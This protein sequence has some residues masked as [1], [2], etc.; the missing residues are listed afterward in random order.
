MAEQIK[1][2][3][4]CFLIM[5]KTE[6]RT[7]YYSHVGTLEI[8]TCPECGLSLDMAACQEID[9]KAKAKAARQKRAHDAKARI[10]YK[11][12]IIRKCTNTIER[13]DSAQQ[14]ASLQRHI[15]KAKKYLAVQR[16]FECSQCGDEL[17]TSDTHVYNGSQYCIDCLPK[18]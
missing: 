13:V 1:C 15:D 10:R 4:G 7:Y 16:I 5:D 8:E 2:N 9:A 14:V 3:C 12:R 18:E 17:A 11:E 6:A